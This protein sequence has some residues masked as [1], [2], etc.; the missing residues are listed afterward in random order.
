[1][2]AAL[3]VAFWATDGLQTLTWWAAQKQHGLQD[4]LARHIRDLRRGDGAA[5]WSLIVACATYGF[6]HALG[7]GHGKLLISGASVATRATARRMA[8]IAVAG[9]LAQAGFAIL[10]VF[11]CFA[12]FAATARG[13]LDVA[14]SWIVPLGNA[15]I[16]AIGA[17]LVLRGLRTLH[18]SADDHRRAREHHGTGC[19]HNHGP[20]PEQAARATSPG[21]TLALIGGMAARPCTGALLVLAVAWRLELPLAGAAAALA[22]GLGTA[23]FTVLVAVLATSTRDAALL[24]AGTGRAARLLAPVLQITAGG[25]IFVVSAGLVAAGLPL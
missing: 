24:G 5:F 25:A 11:G 1:V 20:T 22:M 14:D 15:A 12:L 7:P 17:W 16:A 19:G 2:L 23:A 13:T 10:I 9:S 18:G 8:L 3:A 21:A 6:V 4:A